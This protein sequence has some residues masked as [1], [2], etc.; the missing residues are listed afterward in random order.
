M[1]P[2][3]VR[4]VAVLAV[5]CLFGLAAFTAWLL[6]DYIADL[7]KQRDAQVDINRGTSQVFARITERLD[8]IFDVVSG[9]RNP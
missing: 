1:D 6:R 3:Q 7:K 8:D 9:K 5:L 4:D 2:S